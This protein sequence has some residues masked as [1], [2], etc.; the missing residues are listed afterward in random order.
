[1]FEVFNIN[2]H[3]YSVAATGVKLREKYFT[4][5]TLAENYMY[6]FLNKRGLIIE[7]IYDD[8]HYKTYCCNTG[9]KIYIN[10]IY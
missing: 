10:R 7:K 5:R 1:M 4:S 9:A 3:Y 8:K 2:K 6:K